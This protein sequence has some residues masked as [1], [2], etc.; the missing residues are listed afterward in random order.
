MKSVLLCIA[1]DIGQEALT[2][3]AHFGDQLMIH[4]TAYFEYPSHF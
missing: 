2:D 1:G 3:L 4:I